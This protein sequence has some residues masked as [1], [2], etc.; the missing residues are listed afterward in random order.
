MIQPEPLLPASLHIDSPASFLAALNWATQVALAQ[1]ARAMVWADPSFDDWPLDDEALLVGLA[2]WLRLPLRQLTL[3]RSGGAALGLRHPRFARWGAI[4]SHAVEWR[5]APPDALS[6]PS[7]AWVER[8]AI[9]VLNDPALW[10]GQAQTERA[11]VQQWAEQIDVVL[12]RS[13]AGP[14]FTTLGL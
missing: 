6:L 3:L 10:L 1:R 7:A 11:A 8:A 9:V 4:W 13:Q 12:Q 5:V 2:A 14:G